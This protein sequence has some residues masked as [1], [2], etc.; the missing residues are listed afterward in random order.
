MDGSVTQITLILSTKHI[1]SN[2]AYSFGT[3]V[4]QKGWRGAILLP[5]TYTT[6]TSA[7]NISLETIAFRAIFETPQAY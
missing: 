1:T 3:R 2:I 4:K 6:S 5:F 7:E